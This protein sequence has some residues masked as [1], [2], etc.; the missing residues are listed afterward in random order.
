MAES[1]TNPELA[2]N[3]RRLF[4]LHA[5][6]PTRDHHML[7]VSPQALSELQS[8]SRATLS[9]SSADRL[10]EFF[11]ISFDRLRRTPFED[12]LG[13]EIADVERFDSVEKKIAA[14]AKRPARR[15]H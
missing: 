10:A 11:E 14:A 3:L 12:L 2:N 15:K 6:R 5:I 8:G 1:N 7:G 13:R 4:G 9:L